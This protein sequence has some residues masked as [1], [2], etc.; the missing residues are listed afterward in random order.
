[1]VR[2]TFAVLFGWA[3]SSVAFGDFL[4]NGVTARRG[5]S[6]R[7]PENTVQ[8]FDAAVA[9][10]VDWIQLDVHRT[11]DGRLVVHH[12][13]TTGRVGD[14]NLVVPDST[15]GE[16]LAVDVAAELR[17]RN[18]ETL[19][20][21]P[22]HAIPLLENVLRRTMRQDR[23]RVSI[24]PKMDCVA[25][26]VALIRQVKAERWVGFND[27]DPARLIEVKQLAP[28]I[29]VF[30]DRGDGDVDEDVFFAKQHGFEALV[31]NEVA[32]TPEKIA[33]IKSAGLKV[34]AWTVND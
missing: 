2:A 24:Q 27:D 16:L 15:F 6:L 18:G 25:D 28:E 8:A 9:A 29:P 13:R 10:G 32:V 1:M 20:Q 7:F 17:R 26:C 33:K 11:R 14:R 19:Q 23:C 3:V 30:W 12:D 22:P 31:L 5:D 34:G 4:D 21:R